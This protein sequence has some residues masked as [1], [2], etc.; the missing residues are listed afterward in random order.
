M[1]I[2]EALKK[3][4]DNTE[5]V[6]DCLEWTGA[7]RGG[8]GIIM[9]RPNSLSPIQATTV[10]WYLQTGTDL[11]PG[12]SIL[13]TCDNPPCV[14]FDHL[15]KSNRQDMQLKNRGLSLLSNEQVIEARSNCV[16]LKDAAILAAKWNVS[17]DT[18]SRA[19]RGISH[20][21][22]DGAHELE[23]KRFP[24][25]SKKLS[26]SDVCEIREALKKPYWGLQK[27]LAKQYGVDDSM[28]TAI[29]NNRTRVDIS[30][31]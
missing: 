20:K 8:Y 29:K 7:K 11:K 10:A 25:Q 5:L 21:Y 27:K 23:E 4:Y 6:G 9:S 24:S 31:I 1:I 3:F 26:A 19:I 18:V 13:H 28:I 17:R 30:E 2:T 12:Q 14:L 16:S 22:L 15:L